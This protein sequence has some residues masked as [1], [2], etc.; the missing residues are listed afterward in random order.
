[1]NANTMAIAQPSKKVRQMPAHFHD[2]PNISISKEF[3][4]YYKT[5]IP[6]LLEKS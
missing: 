2:Q 4:E 6:A 3:D 1:M 5:R